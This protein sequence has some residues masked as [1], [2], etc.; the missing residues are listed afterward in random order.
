MRLVYSIFLEKKTLVEPRLVEVKQAEADM[1]NP[2][3][4]KVFFN[5]N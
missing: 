3:Y 4:N 2:N 5:A 1:D